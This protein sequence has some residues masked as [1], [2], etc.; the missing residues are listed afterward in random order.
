MPVLGDSLLQQLDQQRYAGLLQPIADQ[1]LQSPAIVDQ[2]QQQYPI[3]RDLG[4]QY[5]KSAADKNGG[6]LE[7]WPPDEQGSP[8][9]PRPAE[10][11]IKKPGVEIY[12]DNVRPIDILGDVV[13]HHLIES[14]PK[15]AKVYSIFKNSITSD[16]NEMLAQQYE[17]AKEHEGEKRSFDQWKEKTG[18]PAFFRGHPFEQWSADFNQKNYTPEQMKLLDGMMRYLQ[19]KK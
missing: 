4:L 15:I 7:F 12:S 3:L 5:K 17:H 19:G 13:S 11:D 8:D 16:Q 6:L 18:I 1:Q 14:D 2:A 10:F 9:R